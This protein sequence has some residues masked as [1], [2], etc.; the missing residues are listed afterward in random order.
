MVLRGLVF[1]AL[2]AVSAWAQ[3]QP[4]FL[5]QDRSGVLRRAPHGPVGVHEPVRLRFNLEGETLNPFSIRVRSQPAVDWDAEVSDDGRYLNLRPHRGFLAS[6]EFYEIHIEANHLRREGGEL[7][8]GVRSV[9]GLVTGDGAFSWDMSLETR[10]IP[11]G[12]S[13]ADVRFAE[14]RSLHWA[15]EAPAFL[16]FSSS[17]S[18]IVQSL[19]APGF[20]VTMFRVGA[21]GRV[22]ALVLPEDMNPRGAFVMEGLARGEAFHAIS[23]TAPG[24]QRFRMEGRLGSDHV[25]AEAS[26]T[27]TRAD[28]RVEGVMASGA[29]AATAIPQIFACLTSAEAHSVGAG[30]WSNGTIIV[31]ASNPIDRLPHLY[32]ALLFHEGHLVDSA[33]A[34]AHDAVTLTLRP[35]GSADDSWRVYVFRDEYMARILSGAQ[36]VEGVPFECEFPTP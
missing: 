25:L 9:G 23:R 16:Q 33:F 21:V 8:D 36:L 31:K 20:F 32:G 10:S 18:G 12:P 34:T 22:A 30:F 29:H 4:G 7:W 26:F 15:L 14:G 28:A 19:S 35:R 3:E 2:F 27:A 6:G 13:D 5:Y 17:S 1:F 24:L 11:M